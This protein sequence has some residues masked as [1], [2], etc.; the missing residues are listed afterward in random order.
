MPRRRF[1]LRVWLLMALVAVAAIGCAVGLA[2]IRRPFFADVAEP[3]AVV[4]A[5]SINNDLTLIF[6][7]AR[8]VTRGVRVH[9]PNVREDFAPVLILQESA[10]RPRSISVPLNSDD[11]RRF[12]ALLERWARRDPDAKA[13]RARADAY[14]DGRSTQVFD[15]TESPEQYAKGLAVALLDRLRWP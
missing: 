11:A 5:W 7:D 4:N 15:G 6:R 12:R 1:R 2:R 8:G 13:F 10:P 3:I 14:Y 9:E